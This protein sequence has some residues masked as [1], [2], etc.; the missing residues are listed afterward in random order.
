MADMHATADWRIC[1]PPLSPTYNQKKPRTFETPLPSTGA[2]LPLPPFQ[3]SDL[4]GLLH[5][6]LDHLGPTWI[7]PFCHHG[8]SSAHGKD[9]GRDDYYY[10]CCDLTA[11]QAPW[12]SGDDA[13][14]AC[15]GALKE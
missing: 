14:A 6:R 2:L 5:P 7:Y 9:D 15:S 8:F 12:P 11:M 13:T 3:A 10:F 1:M 4:R